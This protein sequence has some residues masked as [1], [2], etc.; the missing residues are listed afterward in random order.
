MSNFGIAIFRKF[1]IEKPAKKK[2]W[3]GELARA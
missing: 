1:G 2:L 3:S